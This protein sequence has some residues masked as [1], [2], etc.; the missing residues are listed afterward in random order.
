M[1]EY[2]EFGSQFGT[3]RED[4]ELVYDTEDFKIDFDASC[5]QNSETLLR[6]TAYAV[7]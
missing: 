3:D 6:A 7:L 2:R 4:I 1:T 5:P